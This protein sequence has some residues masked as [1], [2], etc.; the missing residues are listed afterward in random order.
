M[1]SR[2]NVVF[3]DVQEDQENGVG[4]IIRAS[5][6][7]VVQTSPVVTMRIAAINGKSV[8]DL[9]AAARADSAKPRRERRPM[10]GLRREYRST[11][12]DSL[13]ASETLVKGKWFVPRATLAQGDTANVSAEE[14]VAEALGVKIG[15]V[16]TWDVQGVEI[17]ARITS[18][19]K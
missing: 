12:R 4:K 6:S 17:P 1:A 2:G 8:T 14:S 15:D 11:F 13:G 5:G 9:V 16:I 19:R 10:W 7:A 18:L 3:F